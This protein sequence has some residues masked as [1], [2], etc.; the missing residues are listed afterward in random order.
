M[1]IMVKVNVR[2]VDHDVLSVTKQLG[3]LFQRDAFRLREHEV[4]QQS[5]KTGDDD[6]EQVKLPADVRKRGRRSLEIDEICQ[7]NRRDRQTYT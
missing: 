5:T 4:H 7:S 2:G 3:H 6:E 1:G